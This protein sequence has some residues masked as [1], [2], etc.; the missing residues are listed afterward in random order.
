[1]AIGELANFT[2]YAFAPASLVTPLGALS[3]LISSLLAHK[4]LDENLNI[5]SQIGC[6]LAI[7]GSTMIVIHTPPETAVQTLDQIS[8][9]LT[10]PLFVAYFFFVITASGFLIF[11]Y[12]PE[13]GNT[14]VMVYTLICSMIGSFSVIASKGLGLS[15][16][17]TIEGQSQLHNPLFWA[18]IGSVVITISIQMNYLNKALD[19]FDTSIVTPIYYVFFTVFVLIA[20]AILYREWNS[21]TAENVLG[22]VCGFSTTVIGIFLLTV[23]KNLDIDMDVLAARLNHSPYNLK[24]NSSIYDPLVP[25]NSL[26]QQSTISLD[27]LNR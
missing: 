11:F 26:R 19:V 25:S 1:M 9:M 24:Q 8:R 3:V 4:F 6:F 17:L 21:M 14:N 5:F 22:E 18:F 27:S 12:A 20:S 13:H 15:V 10:R 7:I 2:A 16:R 23:F